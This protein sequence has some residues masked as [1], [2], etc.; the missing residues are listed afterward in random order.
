MEVLDSGGRRHFL[1][2]HFRLNQNAQKIEPAI[3]H[4]NTSH[5]YIHTEA[6]VYNTYKATDDETKINIL[7]QIIPSN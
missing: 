3:T 6:L 4:V 1:I 5:R 2:V 7:M